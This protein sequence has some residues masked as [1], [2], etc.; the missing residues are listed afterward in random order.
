MYDVVELT[1][2]ITSISER[3]IVSPAAGRFRPLPP[4]TFTCEGEWVDRGQVLGIVSE[5]GHE[6]DIVSG[7]SGWVM[8]M[9]AVPGQPI[10]KGEALFWVKA[11]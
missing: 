7:F 1:P 10:T 8:G 4:E 3:V 11:R 9:L 2:E 5:N 6:I